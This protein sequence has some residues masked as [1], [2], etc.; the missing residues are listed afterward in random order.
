MTDAPSDRPDPLIDEVRAI[1]AKIMEEVD[2]DLGKLVEQLREIQ[3]QQE[4]NHPIRR[5]PPPDAD[6]RR[7]AS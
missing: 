7:A 2:N 3:R 6:Q 4:H 5:L 1:R